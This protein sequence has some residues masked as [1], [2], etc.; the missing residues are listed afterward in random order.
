MTVIGIKSGGYRLS[1]YVRPE[2]SDK[3][4]CEI[5]YTSVKHITTHLQRV[6][7]FVT[8]RLI[9][10]EW[11]YDYDYD[12]NVGVDLMLRVDMVYTDGDA[13]LEE[14]ETTRTWIQSDGTDGMQTISSKK[15]DPLSAIK[16]AVIRRS[17]IIDQLK[18]SVPALIMATEGDDLP[19]AQAKGIAFFDYLNSSVDKF[20]SVN[21]EY[22][23]T[24]ID[25]SDTSPSGFPWLLNDIGGGTTIQ[26]FIK[27]EID[28]LAE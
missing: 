5:D 21:D 3:L 7:T 14:R 17:N 22:I 12:F 15:Y 26:Q 24:V 1:E 19:T 10:V 28:Y 11:W 25:N 9:K 27:A 23:L 2:Y 18:L 6:N 4:I 13:F 20:I 8:G 16:E